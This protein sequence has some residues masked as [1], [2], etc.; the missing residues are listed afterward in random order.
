MSWLTD[1]F[2]Y[3][4]FGRAV[5]AGCLVGLVCGA[6]GVF[7]VLRR[8]AYIGHGLSYS[9]IG[10]VAVAAT[11]EVSHYFGAAVATAVAALLIDR[12]RRVEGLGADT[13][14]GVVSTG[15]FAMGVA[16]ISANR[17]KAP[18]LE[19]LLFGNVLGV[20]SDD[21][22]ILAVVTALAAAV[23]FTSYKMLAFAT[24]DAEM[25][26]VHGV[27]TLVIEL[28]FNLLVGAVVVVSLR[29]V[30]VLLITAVIVFP[31]AVARIVCPTLGL[32]VV[33][34]GGVGVSA[35]VI[36]LYVSFHADLASGPAIVL[37]DA[38]ILA[39]ALLVTGALAATR[40]AAARRSVEA[41]SSGYPPERQPAS[42]PPSQ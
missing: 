34:A 40:R 32:M 27:P 26:R 12:I 31:A 6:L 22:V 2:E 10:G 18:N 29:V 33:T 28:G 13:A 15:L 5:L 25:A 3:A 9:L 37:A 36:G 23:L 1:P 39:A 14:I 8:M 17:D 21:V 20:S 30:G 24:Q 16:V 38:G 41:P 4:F 19:N 42:R 7:V 35:A 11:L